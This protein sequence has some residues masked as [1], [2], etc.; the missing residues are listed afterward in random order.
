V[1]ETSTSLKGCPERSYYFKGK[2]LYD[3]CRVHSS[4]GR[5]INTLAAVSAKLGKIHAIFKEG[6]F[7]SQD[8]IS[9]FKQLQQR[10]KHPYAL[11]MDN[12]SIHSSKVTKS[13]LIGQR[14][15][16]VYVP[17]YSPEYS[18]IETVFAHHKRFYRRLVGVM[19]TTDVL[20]PNL[21]LTM[22]AWEAIPDH[23]VR[24]ICYGYL[25]LH[26]IK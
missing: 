10:I 13:Y 24:K 20:R 3:V 14:I 19:R 1:D 17:P 4:G 16:Y 8:V 7:D 15:R 18:P 12:A 21:E 6:A 5:N 26:F 22:D 2:K 9:F 23:L 25:K 11:V